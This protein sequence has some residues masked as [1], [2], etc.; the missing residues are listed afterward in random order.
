MTE[1]ILLIGIVYYNNVNQMFPNV[2]CNFV[3]KR[4]IMAKTRK[5]ATT[6]ADQIKILESRGVVVNDY[7]KAKEILSDIGYYRLGFYF[8]PFEKTYPSLDCHRNH[9]VKEYTKFE[10]AV[11]LYYYDFDLRNILNK[12]LSRIEVAF[13]TTMIYELS[14]KYHKDP[15]WFVNPSV[16]SP[17]FIRD[18]PKE[19]YRKISKKD[20]I[21]RHK[22]KHPHDR[23]A[24]AWKTMEFMVFGNLTTL[25]D[26]LLKIDDKRLISIH[27]NVNKISV[28]FNYIE[29]IR[30][31]RNA[32]AHGN[33]LYD[34]K[35][36]TS[37]RRGPAGQ[38]NDQQNNRLYSVLS[39]VRYILN[40]ISSNRLY[41]MNKE[42]KDATLK[43]YGKCPAIRPLIEQRTGIFV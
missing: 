28:F 8:F 20:V 6:F 37:V 9:E 35:L 1:N 12:Y 16:V 3:F 2:F 38:F 23:Y 18:F 29:A 21:K 39:V 42:L 11:A 26:N 22:K 40:T 32:C 25:Y 36:E 41:D 34:M 24:P 31:L 5:S 27:F 17:S 14:I 4:Q 30:N 13:R 7:N 19:V 10:D 33:L 15:I 43:L